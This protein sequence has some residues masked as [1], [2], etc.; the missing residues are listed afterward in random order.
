MVCRGLYVPLRNKG[1]ALSPPKIVELCLCKCDF[2][3]ISMLI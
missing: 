1:L 2:G 3:H